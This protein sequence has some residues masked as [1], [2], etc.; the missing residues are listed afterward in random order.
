[1]YSKALEPMLLFLFL[2]FDGIKRNAN[3]EV[4]RNCKGAIKST[5][6]YSNILTVRI[7]HS[8]GLRRYVTVNYRF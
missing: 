8:F 5:I 2:L 3:S 6:V 1:M 4:Y 7:Q